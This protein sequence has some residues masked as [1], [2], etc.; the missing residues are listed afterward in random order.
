M[1]LLWTID[2]E[3]GD[4]SQY[5]GGTE[6]DGGDLGVEENAGLLGAHLLQVLIDDTNGV[7]ARM[8]VTSPASGQL[9]GMFWMDVNSLTMDNG[10]DH[11]V[12]RV[13]EQGGGGSWALTLYLGKDATGYYFHIV[14][15]DDE[16]MWDK[17]W[18][19]QRFSDEPHYFEWFL[20]RESGDGNDDGICTFWI[21]GEQ[22]QTRS[23]VDNWASF[24]ALN[25]LSVGSFTG[26]D[27][28]TSGALLFDHLVMRDD[29]TPIGPCTVARLD[30]HYRHH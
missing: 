17:G 18:W 23:D 7:Y 20:Q 4:L 24:G 26:V 15:M 12:Y 21:D 13:Y 16:G 5:D 11:E 22:I 1:S 6:T 29:D 3:T 14:P 30:Y 9:R 8:Q 27:A 28:T 2:H 25:G 19:T 10:T